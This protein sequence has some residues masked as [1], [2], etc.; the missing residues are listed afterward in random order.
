MNDPIVCRDSARGRTRTFSALPILL[1]ACA[2]GSAAFTPKADAAFTSWG[3]KNLKVECATWNTSGGWT[4]IAAKVSVHQYT[5]PRPGNA[6]RRMELKARMVP[7]TSGSNWLRGW[8]KIKTKTM[9]YSDNKYWGWNPWVRTGGVNPNAD[10]NVEV[11]MVWNRSRFR[12]FKYKRIYG[13]NEA[14]CQGGTW[15]APAVRAS[16]RTR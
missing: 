10:W 13:F 6:L 8:A 11:E 3:F 14:F 9:H 1:L 2:L 5:V 7:T 15:R 4:Q 12:K 16:S